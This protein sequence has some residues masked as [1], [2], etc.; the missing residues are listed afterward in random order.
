[1]LIG[2][3]GNVLG[4]IGGGVRVVGICNSVIFGGFIFEVGESIIQESLLSQLSLGL[5]R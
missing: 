2:R 3:I 4:L 1:M 5:L